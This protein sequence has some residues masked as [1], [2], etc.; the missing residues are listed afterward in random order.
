V[1][2]AL[3]NGLDNDR[4]H[5]AYLFTGTRG[6]GKTTIARILAK[7]LNCDE[8]V[9]S[10]P[11][12]VCASCTEIAEGRFVDLIEVDAASRTKVE[13]TRELLENVQYLPT[14]GR[15]KVYLIDEVHMLTNHSFNALLKTLEEPPPH[16]KFLLATTDPQKLPVTVLSRCLQFN[17]KNLGPER[18]VSH[19]NHIL[20][21]EKIPYEESA[22]W[23]LGRAA[24]GSMRDALSLTDQ[25]IA[26]GGGT[27]TIAEVNAMLG[28]IDRSSVVEICQAI[29]DSD[30]ST[31]MSKV[32]VLADHSPDY[33]AALAD[34]LALWHQVAI[35]Q[36]LPDALDPNQE[37]HEVVLD[38]ANRLSREDV[39]LFYQISL[40][41]RK[42][43]PYGADPRSG[44]EMVLLR[45][46]AFKPQLG[47]VAERPVSAQGS[48]AAAPPKKPE[49]EIAK[50]APSPSA[51]KSS[52]VDHLKGHVAPNDSGTSKIE[53]SSGP[54]ETVESETAPE[55]AGKPA[56]KSVSSAE[57]VPP[58]QPVQ[59]ASKEPGD[60]EEV[61]PPWVENY[62]FD[63]SVAE[64]SSG[65]AAFESSTFLSEPNVAPV[66]SAASITD[67]GSGPEIEKVP[68]EQ[69]AQATWRQVCLGLGNGGLIQNLAADTSLKAVD[70]NRISLLL[71][72]NNS[73]LYN[74]SLRERLQQ[75][76]EGYFGCELV[77]S[78]CIGKVDQET[79]RMTSARLRHERLQ[80]AVTSLR[81]D[82]NVD[83]LCRDFS[84]QLVESSVKPID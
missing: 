21:E 1:L 51:V 40:L 79:P 12:G 67:N 56:Q 69:L 74:E 75:A 38:L 78:V 10:K 30:V 72:E 25:A 16:V 48:E 6:V 43:L 7:C 57:P 35:A 84:A 34:M 36:T 47:D 42:D 50:V 39:Q 2:R 60:S 5:H 65:A 11:C 9:S 73:A 82:P 19:L 46:I 53:V 37:H 49:P 52:V 28:T 64:Q 3:I 15:F 13:D 70:G 41:G 26:H 83:A 45:M 8:G 66:E 44:F 80:M 32:D 18:I 4:L 29:A 23:A 20:G 61:P 54:G 27:L 24:D 55:V 68:L 59:E 62:P 22:L 81:K 71:D 31:M 58:M 63:E 33:S 76:L 14:R 77:V 17:L